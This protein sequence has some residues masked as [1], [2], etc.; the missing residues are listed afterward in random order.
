M[1]NHQQLSF[2]KIP[3][4][5]ERSNTNHLT[6]DE[7]QHAARSERIWNP[8]NPL[9]TPSNLKPREI[10]AAVHWIVYQILL[11]AWSTDLVSKYEFIK[12]FWTSFVILSIVVSDL[13]HPYKFVYLF[14]LVIKHDSTWRHGRC[15]K[16][17][18]YPGIA[19]LLTVSTFYLYVCKQY[20]YFSKI[21]K[22]NCV[23]I[24][25]SLHWCSVVYFSNHGIVI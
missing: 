2:F 15:W 5:Y 6:T 13:F 19:C 1:G 11:Y 17:F 14:K 9:S 3:E 21:G 10:F 25:T 18:G 22:G 7:L 16:C 23:H 20:W 4:F 24:I 12:Y 8:N